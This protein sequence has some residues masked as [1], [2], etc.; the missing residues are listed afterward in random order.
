MPAQLNLRSFRSFREGH[1]LPRQVRS[2]EARSR[3]Y[4]ARRMMQTLDRVRCSRASPLARRQA[5]EGEEALAGF[6]Q[7]VGDGAVTEPPLSDE[8]LTAGLDFLGRGGVDHVG[9]IGGDLVV[10]ALGRV[11]E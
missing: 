2:P 10:Q 9:V 3:R 7:A 6:L 4:R 5:G 8:G 1:V 11:G